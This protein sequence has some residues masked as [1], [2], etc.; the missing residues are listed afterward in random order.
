MEKKE[1]IP[2]SARR[3]RA[4][5]CM[6]RGEG[7]AEAIILAT[8]QI[9]QYTKLALKIAQGFFHLGHPNYSAFLNP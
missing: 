8:G 5:L 7:K 4:E 6:N 2:I 1:K 3:Q 9:F